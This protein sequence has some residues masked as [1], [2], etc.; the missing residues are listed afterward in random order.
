MAELAAGKENV[1]ETKYARRTKIKKLVEEKIMLIWM[2][3][4]NNKSRVAVWLFTAAQDLHWYLMPR[5]Y[6]GT[7]VK[8]IICRT[9]YTD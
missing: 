1:M 6:S 3:D 9:E 4:A 7:A 8:T 2:S 5:C